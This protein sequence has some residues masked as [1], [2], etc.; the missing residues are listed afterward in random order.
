[1]FQVRN[2][3][4]EIKNTNKVLRKLK[5]EKKQVEEKLMLL[6]KKEKRF[7]SALA[8]MVGA[9][10]SKSY[11]ECEKG[12]EITRKE[13]CNINLRID[14]NNL[15]KKEINTKYNEATE[16][17]FQ[18]LKNGF[19]EELLQQSAELGYSKAVEYFEE[20]EA[21]RVLKEEKK[22]L[23]E[24][25][26]RRK[27]E[28]EARFQQIISSEIIDRNELINIADAGHV[29]AGVEMAKLLIDD[30][31]SEVY[32]LYE[33]KEKIGI[34]KRYLNKFENEGNEL[35]F[36]YRFCDAAYYKNYL[37]GLKNNLKRINE[38]KNAGTLSRR[39][40][41]LA[42]N[43]I[44]QMEMQIDKLETEEREEKVRE[45][46]K[47]IS[48]SFSSGTDNNSSLCVHYQNGY[49]KHGYNAYYDN[50]SCG[51]SECFQ[52]LCSNYQRR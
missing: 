19:D 28:L 49:C 2:F 13:L 3:D 39:Y 11:K 35:E 24:E 47:E 36:L 27:A 38:I 37:K 52:D 42:E 30:Y 46:E 29:N 22:R 20:K 23:R 45:S 50:I 8:V 5:Q 15:L 1:M 21:K 4:K 12:L 25:E 26:K 6:E 33:K 17:Y 9:N 31:F 41:E 51:Y 14:E 44:K 48:Y 18:A 43:I 16:L 40:N 34:A 10:K 32:T 7:S